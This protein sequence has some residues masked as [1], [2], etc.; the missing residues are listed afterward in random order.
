V[1]KGQER[2]GVDGVRGRSCSELVGKEMRGFGVGGER[3][4]VVQSGWR[5]DRRSSKCREV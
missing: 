3:T 1:G 4:G 5:E 2:F